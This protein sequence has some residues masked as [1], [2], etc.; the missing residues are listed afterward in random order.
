MEYVNNLVKVEV[1]ENGVALVR[2]DNPPLNAVT[3]NLAHELYDALH[4]LDRDD[5][6]RAMVLSG[7]GQKAFSVGSDVKEFPG[8]WDDVVERKLRRENEAFNAIEFLSVPTLAAL[9]A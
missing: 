7:T 5:R 8:V 9:E 4:A 1:R 3:V 6:V 2:L